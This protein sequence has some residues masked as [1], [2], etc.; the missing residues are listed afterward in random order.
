MGWQSDARAAAQKNGINPDVFVALVRQES[1]GRQGAV[2]PV[3]AIGRTQLMPATAKSLGVDPRNAQQN[4]DGG[5]RYLKQQLQTFGGNY[6][7]ALAAYN[8]GP[9]AVQKYGGVPPYAETQN[10][11][12]RILGSTSPTSSAT[13][14]AATTKTTT[15]PGVDNHAAR[16]S[17]F[18]GY[19]QD[20]KTRNSPNG[21][22]DL[23]ATLKSLKDTPATTKTVAAS[24]GGADAVGSSSGRGPVVVAPG[25]ERAGIGLQKPV[26]S[27][28]HELAG[29]SGRQVDVTT[30]TNH[31]RMTTSGNVSDHWEGNA[32]DLGVGGDA[33]QNRTAAQKGDLIAAHA[34][35]LA[36]GVSFDKALGMARRGGVFNFETKSGRVQILWRTLTGG[37]HYNHVHVGLN[38]KR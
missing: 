32:A 17:A 2:S 14:P 13:A 36:G 5:A 1:G 12:K 18:L 19:L 20:D 26:L 7:K 23:A 29:A 25:A 3:G 37:N 15:V 21:F 34:I 31:N 33:R 6:R 30:G 27:F 22:L 10:Y 16:A 35:S 9:G 11:V 28:L 24:G 8:A 38:P 4:L